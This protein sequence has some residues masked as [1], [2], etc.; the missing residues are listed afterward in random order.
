[1]KANTV[2]D[3]GRINDTHYVYRAVVRDEMSASEGYLRIEEIIKRK[4]IYSQKL[5]FILTFV[6]GFILC[7]SSFGGSINDMWVAGLL[8]LVVTLAQIRAS[9]S[10]LNSS[11]AE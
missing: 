7:G 10:Q 3:L 5:L 1:M 6:Q 4:P 11:G 9:R 2:L 8:S